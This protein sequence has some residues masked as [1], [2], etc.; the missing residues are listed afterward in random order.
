MRALVM[1]KV[2]NNRFPEHISIGQYILFSSVKYRIKCCLV[3]A[4]IV[5][6]GDK[7]KFRILFHSTATGS[8]LP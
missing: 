6:V 3:H 7:I 1:L 4:G 2:E 8:F 5:T